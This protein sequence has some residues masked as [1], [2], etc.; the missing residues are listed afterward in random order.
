MKSS[1]EEAFINMLRSSNFKTTRSRSRD[2]GP[3]ISRLYSLQTS[4]PKI[5]I[6]HKHE[7]TALLKAHDPSAVTQTELDNKINIVVRLRPFLETE[8]IKG[9]VKRVDDKHSQ[10][11]LK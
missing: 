10:L 5:K 4:K 7:G 8:D 2:Q 3:R 11:I 6:S 1:Q 9:C